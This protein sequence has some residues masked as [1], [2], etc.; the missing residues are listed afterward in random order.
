MS[1]KRDIRAFLR[2]ALVLMLGAMVLVAGRSVQAQTNFGTIVGTVTD[3]TGAEVPGAQVTV[4]NTGTNA[5][6]VVTSGGGGTYTFQNLTPGTY[7]V[8]V[9]SKGFKAVT[10]SEI[11]VTIGGT[12]RVDVSLPTGDVS[13]TVTVEADSA[14]AL[15]T[16][17]SSLG[18]VVEGRQVLESPL[19]GRNVNNLLDFIPGVVPGGGTSGNTL[20]NGGS[21]AFRRRRR[22]R[23]SLMATTRSAAVSAARAC[24]L[25]T[26]CFRTFRRTM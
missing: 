21:G 8:T 25:S 14:T 4:K 12:S 18:G 16:D 13:Q 1:I 6:Q 11:D 3:T 19:N 20:A 22:R 7:E 24:S 17:T 2:T 23:R 10:R 26:A 9:A 5:T 15:Q